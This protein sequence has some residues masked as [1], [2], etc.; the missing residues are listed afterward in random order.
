[1]VFRLLH[2]TICWIWVL[3]FALEL[4]GLFE[5]FVNLD[6]R[7][8]VSL[9]LSAYLLIQLWKFN[10]DVYLSAM[11]WLIWGIFNSVKELI[12][13]RKDKIDYEALIIFSWFYILLLIITISLMYIVRKNVFG[14]YNWFK[15]ALDYKNK[16]VFQA[17]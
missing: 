1:M 17:Q 8:L 10:G 9:A 13:L 14:Y 11:F 4:L 3:F 7:V 15:P 5:L 6:I 12:N 2:K 16:I